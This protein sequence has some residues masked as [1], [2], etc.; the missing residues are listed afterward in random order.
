MPPH[1]SGTM[2]RLRSA[3]YRHVGVRVPMRVDV[4]WVIISAVSQNGDHECH[5]RGCRSVA[6]WL[7]KMT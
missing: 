5:G 3:G 2:H 4:Q 6:E 1:G 7:L